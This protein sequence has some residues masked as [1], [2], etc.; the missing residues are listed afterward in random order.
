MSEPEE[1][2][3]RVTLSPFTRAVTDLVGASMDH[4]STGMQVRFRAEGLSMYPSIRDGELITV[5]PVAGGAI[6]RGDVLLCRSGNRVLAHRVVAI[7]GRGSARVLRLRGDAKLACDAP[8]AVGQVIGKVE[9]VRRK[10]K[11]IALCGPLARLRYHARR[12]AARVKVVLLSS[13]QSVAQ[14]A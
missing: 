9:S 5:G 14:E 2:L 8:I 1:Q 13:E 3:P 4:G 11:T 7:S 12:A 10:G 6:V